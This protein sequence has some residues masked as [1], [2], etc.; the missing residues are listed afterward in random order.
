MPGQFR[1][2]FGLEIERGAHA[3]LTSISNFPPVNTSTAF[4]A[5]STSSQ[6]VTS[7]L[8]VLMPIASRSFNTF[9]F[10]AVAMTWSPANTRYQHPVSR[11]MVCQQP[12]ML[13]R[14]N[15]PFEWNSLASACPMPPSEHLQQSALDT[16][17]R[18]SAT[19]PVIST[20]F[21]GFSAAMASRCSHVRYPT[22]VQRFEPLNCFLGT[23]FTKLLSQARS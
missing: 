4:L 7:R 22:C 6:F 19:Y 23:Q 12:A 18:I 21:L 17:P 8:S 13:L 11:T 10:R 20:L 5:F 9:L 2:S 1:V 14:N 16:V 3:L 15:L